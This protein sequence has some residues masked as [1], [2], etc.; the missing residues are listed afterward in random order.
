MARGWHE[1]WLDDGTDWTKWTRQEIAEHFWKAGRLS[2]SSPQDTHRQITRERLGAAHFDFGAEPEIVKRWPEPERS[3]GRATGAG[4]VQSVYDQICELARRACD[5]YKDGEEVEVNIQGGY[6]NM[7]VGGR[8]TA[9][10][11]YGA[12]LQPPVSQSATILPHPEAQRSAGRVEAGSEQIT[13]AC[14]NCWALAQCTCGAL[15]SVTGAVTRE[16][17]KIK[18]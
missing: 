9:R 1:E 17:G 3:D 15:G 13:H 4:L 2:A 7:R 18:P 12:Q 16:G 14:Q 8:A 11:Y 6:L 5:D 10:R